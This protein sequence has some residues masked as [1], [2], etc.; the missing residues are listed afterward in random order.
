MSAPLSPLRGQL[1]NG[2]TGTLWVVDADLEG[3]GVVAGSDQPSSYNNSLNIRPSR[4]GQTSVV[5]RHSNVQLRDGDLETHVGKHLHG[6]RGVV[7]SGPADKVS[8]ETIAGE[9]RALT[10]ELLGDSS[11]SE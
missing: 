10:E 1:T 7:R 4:V 11:V 6:L 3:I 9:G 5:D 2:N 8:L